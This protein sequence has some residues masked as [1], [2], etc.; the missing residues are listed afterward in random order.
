MIE[1]IGEIDLFVSLPLFLNALV[2]VVSP[3]VGSQISPIMKNIDKLPNLEILSL[4]CDVYMVAS[5][6]SGYEP[7]IIK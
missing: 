3:E 4:S 7:R 1:L 6:R 5:I 2:Y